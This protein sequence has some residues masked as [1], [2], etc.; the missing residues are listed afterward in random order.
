MSTDQG[1]GERLPPFNKEAE[2][3][4]L[5]SMLRDKS[6]VFLYLAGGPSQIETFDTRRDALVER[7]SMTGERNHC[8]SSCTKG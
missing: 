7:R 2:Q 5:G 4:V 6:I 3:S 1:R 8:L